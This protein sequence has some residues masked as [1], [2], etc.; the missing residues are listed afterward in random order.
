M[1]DLFL[2]GLRKQTRWLDS[3]D[4]PLPQRPPESAAAFKH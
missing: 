3:L 2:D 4:A 1:A